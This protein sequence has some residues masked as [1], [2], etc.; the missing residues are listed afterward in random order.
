M[1]GEHRRGTTM[2]TSVITGVSISQTST[3]STTHL[4]DPNA[5]YS[6]TNTH[7]VPPRSSVCCPMRPQSRPRCSVG[8][9]RAGRR[10]PH[11]HPPLVSV[12]PSPEESE[13]VKSDQRGERRERGCVLQVVFGRVF[14]FVCVCVCV[15]VCVWS[16]RALA[17]GARIMSWGTSRTLS[18]TNREAERHRVE[19]NRRGTETVTVTGRPRQRQQQR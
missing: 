11:G 12:S 7:H 10:R 3:H 13:E 15:C 2:P 14:V 5:H 19:E 16:A 17:L 18:T 4:T 6:N 8:P 1:G 9:A